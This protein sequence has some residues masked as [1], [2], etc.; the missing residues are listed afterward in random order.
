MLRVAGHAVNHAEP[1]HHPAV[2]PAV[3]ARW[4]QGA[5]QDVE[6]LGIDEAR[7]QPRTARHVAL[8]RAMARRLPVRDEQARDW[9]QRLDGLFARYDVL[10]LPTLAHD[11]PG[12]HAW[13]T[14]SWL[15]NAAA[16]LWAY[17]LTSAFNL[18][19]VP[20]AAVPLGTHRGRPLSVQ[21]V[22][23][24]GREDLVLA[25]AAQLE[26]QRPWTRHAPG[27]GVPTS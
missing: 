17:P 8:G 26:R 6:L 1:P 20:V 23:A 21:V 15:A 5:A 2:L 13:H 4:T 12:A 27:W 24:Q 7:L 10:V 22:A 11:P 16:N 25:V 19:D 3:L 14:R 9:Q 18:A